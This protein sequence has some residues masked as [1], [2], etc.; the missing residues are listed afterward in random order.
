MITKNERQKYIN[1][2]MFINYIE[3]I[4]VWIKIETKIIYLKNA[5]PIR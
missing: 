2:K 3:N 5:L 4:K 1:K